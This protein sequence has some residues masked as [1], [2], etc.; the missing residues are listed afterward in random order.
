VLII[1]AL[2]FPV[3]TNGFVCNLLMIPKNKTIRLLLDSML[4]ITYYWRLM[5]QFV[6]LFKDYL[7]WC[8]RCLAIEDSIWMTD[9][10]RSSKIKFNLWGYLDWKFAFIFLRKLDSIKNIISHFLPLLL[11]LLTPYVPTPGCRPLSNTSTPFY[12]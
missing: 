3:A 9:W 1:K 7:K 11:L 8:L 10:Y 12:F 2:I 4:F 5:K 6:T